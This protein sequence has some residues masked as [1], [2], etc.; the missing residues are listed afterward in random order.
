MSEI[1]HYLPIKVLEN[2]SNG[3]T[4]IKLLEEP[5]SGIIYTYGQVKFN[6]DPENDKLTIAFEYEVLDYANKAM[7]DMKPFESYIGDIL[8]E[9][10]HLGVQQNNISYTGGVDENRAEDSSESGT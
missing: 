10:I 3:M 5:F 1:P 7:T 8:T 6:E 9:L 2:R 4:A